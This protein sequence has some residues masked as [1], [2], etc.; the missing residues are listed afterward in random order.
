MAVGRLQGKAALITGG[1]SGLGRAM[2]I[3]F[4]AE[5]ARVAIADIEPA[6]AETVAREIGDAALAFEH[7]VRD[8]ASWERTLA[9]AVERL[10][11]LHILVNNAGVGILNNVERT[12]LE[13]WHLVHSVNLDGVFLGCKHGIRHIAAAGG[14]A[15]LNMSSVAGL[16][17]AHNMAAY[18]SSKGA[19]R[20]LTKSV[21]LHCARRKNGV[22][23]NSIHPAYAATPMVDRMVAGSR[24]PGAK[25][26]ALAEAIP[27]GRLGE[28]DEVAAMAV[29][30]A[31]DEARLVTGA[32]FV[33]DGGLSAG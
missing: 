27:L 5:G 2:A 21:A 14:G 29:Y 31:S 4:A 25:R 22:R 6:G 20:L 26:R 28:P 11:G 16:I 30:L 23:C 32:E 13:E 15:I 8:E 9:A 7:D 1:A 24:D 12:T 10:G 17:G 3:A 18:C 33:I 19:V